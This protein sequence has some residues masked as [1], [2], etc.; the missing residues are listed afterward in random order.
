MGA[1][2]AKWRAVIE[3]SDTLPTDENQG[4]MGERPCQSC[5]RKNRT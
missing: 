4:L 2:F 1:R 5:Y 3:V